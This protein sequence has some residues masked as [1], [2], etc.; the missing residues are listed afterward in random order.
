M[1]TRPLTGAHAMCVHEA[2]SEGG[3]ARPL[4][5]A[6]GVVWER[7]AALCAAGPA[8]R[9]GPLARRAGAE[10]GHH[11]VRVG[12]ADRELELLGPG[13]QDLRGLPLNVAEYS[14]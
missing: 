8:W 11:L 9:P 3:G 5:R 10:G 1:R 6:R 13:R 12:H 14:L 4:R 2:P 7:K